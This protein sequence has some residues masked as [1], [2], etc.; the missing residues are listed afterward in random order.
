MERKRR[1]R[2]RPPFSAP[3]TA[4]HAAV[5]RLTSGPYPF[6]GPAPPG[7]PLQEQQGQAADGTE[8][9]VTIVRAACGGHDSQKSSVPGLK[10]PQR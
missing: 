3:R 9:H 1:Q 2:G 4:R 6:K 7:I 10:V 5:H 8:P